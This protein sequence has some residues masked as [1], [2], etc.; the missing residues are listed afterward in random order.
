MRVMGRPGRGRWKR[1]VIP[2]GFLE[3]QAKEGMGAS[4]HCSQVFKCAQLQRPGRELYP[5]GL[6]LKPEG[7]ASSSKAVD[8][9]RP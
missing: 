9:F 5:V 7:R 4:G 6:F 8:S 2:E 1:A 3:G